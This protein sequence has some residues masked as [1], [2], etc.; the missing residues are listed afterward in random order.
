MPFEA[1]GQIKE[2]LA[3]YPDRVDEISRRHKRRT[4]TRT[5]RR[6]LALGEEVRTDAR[7][8]QYSRRSVH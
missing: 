1:M 7:F 2:H 6:S 8:K 5:R 4:V 3:F